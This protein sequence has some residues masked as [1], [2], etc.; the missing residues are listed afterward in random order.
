MTGFLSYVE[1]QSKGKVADR[2]SYVYF[3]HFRVGLIMKEYDQIRFVPSARPSMEANPLLL[4]RE[5][6]WSI[7]RLY[8]I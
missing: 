5:H 2:L 7:L 1:H 4:S 8:S 3:R 6:C